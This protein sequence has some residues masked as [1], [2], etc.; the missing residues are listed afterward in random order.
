MAVTVRGKFAVFADNDTCISAVLE[1]EDEVPVTGGTV[2]ATL[3]KASVD[4][5]G[6]VWP[7]AMPETATPG[8]YEA[9]LLSTL[10]IDDGDTISV[11]VDGIGPTG[12]VYRSFDDEVK[13][14]NK[15]LS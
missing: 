2:T 10:G 6:Q 13:V 3:Q 9:T 11:Q 5:T 15:P 12:A 8:T 14:I 7:L 1:D 4:V